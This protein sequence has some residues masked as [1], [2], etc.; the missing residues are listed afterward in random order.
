MQDDTRYAGWEPSL[1]D[2]IR[3]SY[4]YR[5]AP[6]GVG[7]AAVESFTGYISRLAAAHAV[8]TGTLVNRELLPRVPYTKGVW[9]EQVPKHLPVYSFYIDAHTLNGVGHRARLWVSLLEQLTSVR[10]LDLLT[11]LPWAS[12]ISCVHLLRTSRVWCPSCYGDE[13]SA[14]QSV[15][16]RLLWAF[17]MVIV[18]PN[19][20]RQLESVC[21]FCGRRQYVFSARSRPGYCS[22]CYG[23]LGC[24]PQASTSDSELT[25]QIMM[26]EMVGELLVAGSTLPAH[27]GLDL[28]R[29]NVHSFVRD[30]GGYR[31]FRAGFHPRHIRDWIRNAAIPRMDSLVMLSRNQNVSLIRLLTER[32]DSGKKPDQ[33]CVWKAHYRVATS[34]VEAALQAALQAAVPPPLQEIANQL[35][36]RT[37]SSLQYRFPALCCEIA[38]RRRTEVRT[39]RPS[40]SK[41]PVPRDRIE[42]ALIEELSK[43][44]FTDLRAVAAS[45]GL[46]SK[47]RLYKDFRDLRLAIV[48]KNATIKKRRLEAIR[49]ALAAAFNEQP[50]PTV[51]EMARRL[52]YATVKPVTSRFPKLTMEL[53][54]CR[55]RL[56]QVKCGHRVNVRVRQRLTEVLHSG[57]IGQ[58][59]P[60]QQ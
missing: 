4:L 10:R 40:R 35:G 18:C 11:T 58:N 25:E 15:Y 14:A 3:R 60:W 47:R 26:A 2:V 24:E 19:H 49:P 30:T 5:L 20:R 36:Y 56:T 37:V 55:R 50:V 59:S 8:E 9:A 16:E 13:S 52:G 44:G 23:W 31:R 51:A 46:S 33:N 22:R 17:Q 29:E 27:F 12:T 21:P 57:I 45:V 1:P 6:I 53:R 38:G 39:S 41:A 34:V 48:A 54:A 42:K 32:I 43:A 7:T 28:F